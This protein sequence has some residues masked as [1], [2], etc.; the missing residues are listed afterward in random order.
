LSVGGIP[1]AIQELDLGKYQLGWNDA[2]SYVFKP[3]KGINEQ[4]VRDIS[5][6]KG[7]P[8]WMTKFRLRSLKHF[9]RKP[10]NPWF[11]SRMPNIDFNDIYYY[12]KPT[13]GG[14]VDEW[15]Q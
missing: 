5:W 9:E 15:D 2:E 1:V 13:E 10:M 4:V 12:I 7:E 14:V 8:D 11:S 6:W 3:A